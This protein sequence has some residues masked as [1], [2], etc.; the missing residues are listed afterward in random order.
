MH[1][2]SHKIAYVFDEVSSHTNT[3][4][5]HTLWLTHSPITS[6]TVCSACNLD[7]LRDTSKVLN[8][9]DKV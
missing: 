2:H 7:M 5:N 8:V 6:L 1:V 9:C 4:E 3:H